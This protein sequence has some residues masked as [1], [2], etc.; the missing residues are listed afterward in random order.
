MSNVDTESNDY[1]GD[2]ETV[3]EYIAANEPVEPQTVIHDVESKPVYYIRRLMKDG[4]IEYAKTGSKWRLT[5][6]VE[7]E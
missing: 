3:Y 6:A 1:V 5:I 2:I 4:R 7:D